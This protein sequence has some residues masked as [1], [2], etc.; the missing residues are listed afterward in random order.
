[1]RKSLWF[2]NGG[3]PHRGWYK[4]FWVDSSWELAFLMWH[5]DH[6]KEIVKNTQNFP[7]PFRSGVKYYRPDFIVEGTYYE[8]KGVMDYRSR[9]KLQY[10]PYPIVIVGP[11]QIKPFLEYAESKYGKDFFLRI[12]QS[13]SYNSQ[14]LEK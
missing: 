9:R 8:I 4:N 5:L 14:E 3:Q 6:G 12:R 1:M 7:Y 2:R 10:F 11:K 13:T